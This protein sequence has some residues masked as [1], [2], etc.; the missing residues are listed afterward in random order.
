[1]GRVGGCAY[2]RTV[3]AREWAYS[4]YGSP[5]ALL[6]TFRNDFLSL[7]IDI[8]FSEQ[9]GCVKTVAH[10]GLCYQ[11]YVRLHATDFD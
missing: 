10:K 11:T 6:C 3:Q 4:R 8:M 5:P 1:M 7:A 2:L 9:G